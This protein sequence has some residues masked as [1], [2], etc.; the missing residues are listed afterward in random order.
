VEC[1]DH[2]G[3]IFP[4]FSDQ[5]CF[6]L[7]LLPYPQGFDCGYSGENGNVAQVPDP[8]GHC[9]LRNRLFN[10]GDAGHWPRYVCAVCKARTEPH[11]ASS[12]DNPVPA[13]GNCVSYRDLADT[14]CRQGTRGGLQD[15]FFGYCDP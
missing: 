5:E 6:N 1:T 10:G 2:A 8:S 12:S 4:V 14:Y 3:G 9:G 11:R 15:W 7:H 13:G